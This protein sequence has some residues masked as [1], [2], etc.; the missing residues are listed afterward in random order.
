LKLNSGDITLSETST[1]TFT[2][3]MVK[4]FFLNFGFCILKLNPCD[5]TWFKTNTNSFWSKCLHLLNAW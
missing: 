4:V 3:Y 2:I 5:I 1:N